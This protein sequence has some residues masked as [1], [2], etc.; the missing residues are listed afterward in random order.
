MQLFLN[1]GEVS[2]DDFSRQDLPRSVLNS[3]FSWCRAEGDDGEEHMGWWADT[4]S[5]VPQDLF[6]SRLWLLQRAKLTDDTVLRA[7]EY[8]EEALQWLI[9]DGVASSV[10]VTAE[11]NG[12]DRLDMLVT[13][14]KPSG[15]D[16]AMRFQDVWS[17]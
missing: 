9:E 10:E 16:I 13:V 6:G 11:R 2:L 14:R 7:K 15:K 12:A 4:F 3:L 17:F 1:G 5:D 8:A